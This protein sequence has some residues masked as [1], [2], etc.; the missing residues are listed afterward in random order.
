MSGV[1]CQE[2]KKVHNETQSFFFRR[3]KVDG[4]GRK[5]IA[6]GIWCEN[7]VEPWSAGL[8]T[9]L[10]SS[11]CQNQNQTIIIRQST[12]EQRFACLICST[13]ADVTQLGYVVHEN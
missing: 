6:V 4:Y 3:F 10:P 5:S 12:G 1:T 7:C 8:C 13:C 9:A 11:S 2:C